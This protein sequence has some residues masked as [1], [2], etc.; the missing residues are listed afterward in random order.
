MK[1]CDICDHK[2]KF[3]VVTTQRA[4]TYPYYRISCKNYCVDTTTYKRFPAHI[5]QEQHMWYLQ[6]LN[7]KNI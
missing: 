5:P 1:K 2:M 6:K 3:G 4:V 7:E